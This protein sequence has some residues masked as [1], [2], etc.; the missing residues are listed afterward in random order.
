VN[1]PSVCGYT[2]ELGFVNLPKVFAYRSRRGGYEVRLAW[3]LPDESQTESEG[4]IFIDK[5]T[6]SGKK[7]EIYFRYLSDP[8]LIEVPEASESEGAE[9]SGQEEA[10]ESEESEE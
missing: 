2:S 1:D 6:K 8:E 10:S 5:D 4:G 7:K 9:V 3:F